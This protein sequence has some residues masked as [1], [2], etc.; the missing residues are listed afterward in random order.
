MEIEDKL[1]T[2]A[3]LFGEMLN[4]NQT[5]QNYL[6]A[7]SRFE[8]DP[9]AQ[10]LF[11]EFTQTQQELTLRQR[12]Q[13]HITDQE[14]Q[15]YNQLRFQLQTHPLIEE[16]DAALS[17]VRVLFMNLGMEISARMGIDFANL[18]ALGKTQYR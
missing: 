1:K 6:A 2:R 8:N 13:E 15:N 5:V 16:R 4:Q 9:S 10:A 7:Q 17:D 14:I 12:Q 11:D 3:S 18:A